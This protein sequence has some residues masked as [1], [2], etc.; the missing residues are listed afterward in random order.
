M[1]DAQKIDCCPCGG[2]AGLE[3]ITV[4]GR[5]RWRVKCPKCNCMTPHFG[6]PA[7]ALAVWN[8][9]GEK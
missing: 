2:Q 1:A 7:L 3:L 5:T 8:Q 6:S 9:P 4:N